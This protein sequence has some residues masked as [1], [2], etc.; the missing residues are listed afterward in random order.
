MIM[1]PIY[2]HNKLH[3]LNK[4][5]FQVTSSNWKLN[6]TSWCSNF[7]FN[8]TKNYHNKCCIVFQHLLPHTISG[9]YIFKWQNGHFHFIVLAGTYIHTI[10]QW[11]WPNNS[12]LRFE[13]HGCIRMCMH[14]P[15]HTHTKQYTLILQGK[16]L[17]PS[18]MLLPF[19]FF[20][21]N[22]NTKSTAH[23]IKFITW[24]HFQN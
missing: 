6:T 10:C 12:K 13:E 9:S 15:P 19:H 18:P 20:L 24:H 1:F 14:S 17:C 2:F 3:K 11:N 16:C 4:V 8:S 21:Q 7:I 23:N 22:Y 5:I